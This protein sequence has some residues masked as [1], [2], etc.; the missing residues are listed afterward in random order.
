MGAGGNDGAEGP[1]HDAVMEDD[2]DDGDGGGGDSGGGH[3]GDNDIEDDEDE[4]LMMMVV[5]DEDA[6]D[7]DEG[8][9]YVFGFFVVFIVLLGP[10]VQHMEVPKL[11]G[12]LEL[13]LPVCSTATAVPD[14]SCV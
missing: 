10:H 9:E 2:G 11:E 8:E 14:L 5:C 13:Q 4:V 6:S 3:D 7:E 1:D 12:E